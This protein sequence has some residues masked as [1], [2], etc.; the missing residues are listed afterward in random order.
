MNLLVFLGYIIQYKISFASEAG[1]KAGIRNIK[2]MLDESGAVWQKFAQMLSGYEDIIGQEIAVELQNMLCECPT[3]SHDYSRKVLKRD[4]GDKYD[5]DNMKLIGSGTIAQVYKV[6]DYAIKIKHP[7]V[8]E[9]VRSAVETYNGVKDSFFFPSSLK[10]LCDIFFKGLKSQLSMR[11]EYRNGLLM[12]ELIHKDTNQTNNLFIIPEMIDHSDDCIVMTYE[13]STPIVLKTREA[14]DKHVLLKACL[15]MN[16]FSNVCLL[17]GFMHS[18][19]HF[20]NFGIRGNDAE[21][22]QLVIYDFGFM[23]D[24]REDIDLKR[25]VK[26]LNASLNY[27]MSHMIDCIF[28]GCD[29]SVIR[30]I[31][32]QMSDIHSHDKINYTNNLRKVPVYIIYNG[33]QI[34]DY[35]IQI[36]TNMEKHIPLIKLVIELEN[37]PELQE[38][39]DYGVKHGGSQS[40]KKYYP[41]D[42][43]KILS[44]LS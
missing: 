1:R 35:I 36:F 5:Y 21:T 12:K 23:C 8:D 20:G 14:I 22:I 6:G 29:K 2:G 31:R 3:H 16:R 32:N 30:E 41:Y 38:Q 15:G 34:N 44:L 19:M 33:I 9:E 18:D 28:E 27:K 40:I 10:S 39:R 37:D 17:H 26:F 11:K 42:D 24:I 25:R 13:E 4:F 7:N 43:C